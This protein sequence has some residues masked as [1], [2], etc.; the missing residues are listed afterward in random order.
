M[1]KCIGSEKKILIAGNGGSAAD[2]LHLAAEFVGRF[3]RE[4]RPLPAISLAADSAAVTAIGNDYGFD[5]VF[6]RQVQAV[7][8]VGDLLFVM[9]T[10]GR[11]PNVIEAVRRGKLAGMG[12]IALVGSESTVLSDLCDVTIRVDS[13]VTSH[14]QEAHIAI[15][16]ALC[17]RLEELL[18]LAE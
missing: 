18:C 2:S 5:E 15:G 7:G 6:A 13:S 11:S 3:R 16:H 1:V 9:T 10:S 4:R 8:A 17:M 14:I 12:S